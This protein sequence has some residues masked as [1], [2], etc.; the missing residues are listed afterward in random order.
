MRGR[1]NCHQSSGILQERKRRKRQQE[2]QRKI[3]GLC[4]GTFLL[5][6]L[7]GKLVFAKD[8]TVDWETVC[9]EGADMSSKGSGDF[10]EIETADGT[11]DETDEESW[12]L[13][14]VNPTTAMEE[15][16]R[17]WV[18]E[19]ENN[20]YFDK[21]AVSHLREMLEGG[22]KEGL[23]FWICSAYRTRE[24]QE[25]LFENKVRRLMAEK[26]IDYE[27]AVERARTEVA[28]PG[29]SEHQL[30][31]AVDI[32]ARDYQMLD[33][34]QENTAEARWL[35]ENCW[36]YGFILRYPTDKTEETGIIYEPWHFRYV[37]KKAAK[38]IMEQGLCLEEYLE[39]R[40]QI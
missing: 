37:G 13:T 9:V 3:L 34:K 31:L 15:D 27:R 23:D 21:R 38:E 22:R 2:L 28:Y 40:E 20:F 24:K 7:L 26:G 12:S 35:K 33:K 30:G 8:K 16:Y 1:N 32:V 29:T 11:E 14:L 39:E 6:V 19:I 4:L 5:G 25:A 10:W 17:P 18:A 36:R